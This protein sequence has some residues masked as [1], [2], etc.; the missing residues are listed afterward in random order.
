MGDLIP[1]KRARQD[2]QP[3]EETPGIISFEDFD[4]LINDNAASK[5]RVARTIADLCK[6]KTFKLGDEVPPLGSVAVNRPFGTIYPTNFSPL[7]TR[8]VVSRW[9]P[10]YLH[11]VHN[12]KPRIALDLTVDY[13]TAFAVC[14]AGVRR[15]KLSRASQD[16]FVPE[17]WEP[18]YALPE[19]SVRA[20]TY[21]VAAEIA[22]DGLHLNLAAPEL[23]EGRLFPPHISA[24]YNPA[25]EETVRS[26]HAVLKAPSPVQ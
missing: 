23:K 13:A 16:N 24:L 4:A 2:S 8:V 18:D 21:R 14:H 10:Q 19:S 7:D 1:F 11:E 5:R 15:T 22:L 9:V 12:L 3:Q 26:M 6:F 17:L 20:A 25:T